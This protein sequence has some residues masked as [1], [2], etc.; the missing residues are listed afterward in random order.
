VGGT[1]FRPGNDGGAR[2]R[3]PL[4]LAALVLTLVMVAGLGTWSAANHFWGWTEYSGTQ[5]EEAGVRLEHPRDWVAK[6]HPGQFAV[7]AP[8][9]LTPVFTPNSDWTIVNRLAA[10]DPDQL[11]GAYV[12]STGWLNLGTTLDPLGTQLERKFTTTA[13]FQILAQPPEGLPAGSQ[14]IVG[15]MTPPDGS[16]APRLYFEFV[17]VQSGDEQ[18]LVL[19]FCLET[20]RAANATTFK[21]VVQSIRL[22]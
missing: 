6:P 15:T 17:A 22:P 8:S 18:G 13:R 11:V 3:R 2:S 20:Q 21:R 5:F 7:L 10:S 1:R 14:G 19:L 16:V 4:R 9:D 12:N